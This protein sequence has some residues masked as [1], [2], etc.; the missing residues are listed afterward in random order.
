MVRDGEAERPGA[1][2]RRRTTVLV[3]T[4]ACGL[5]VVVGKRA[6]AP[7][8][9]ARSLL[10]GGLA[11]P[12]RGDTAAAG[13]APEPGQ[14]AG[15]LG[16]WAA[17]T[18][19]VALRA[20]LIVVGARSV[21]SRAASWVQA[22]LAGPPKG[23]DE[24]VVAREGE[25]PGGAEPPATAGRGDGVRV[26]RIGLADSSAGAAGPVAGELAPRSERSRNQRLDTTPPDERP[27]SG[28]AAHEVRRLQRPPIPAAPITSRPHPARP[29]P[30][31]RRMKALPP[32]LRLC[33]AAR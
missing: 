7:M 26:A 6:P 24:P 25:E 13:A 18:V 14:S 32:S 17:K 30:M 12:C 1:G 15:G 3:A 21:A 22:A 28:R 33:G 10:C 20:A 9:G 4:V 2:R 19:W 11:L 8:E 31:N 27:A 23:P 5:T 29:L 16:S